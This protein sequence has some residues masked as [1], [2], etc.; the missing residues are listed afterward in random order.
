[1]DGE[2]ITNPSV[3]MA[4]LSNHLATAV[5]TSGNGKTQ[6]ATT[7]TKAIF[8]NVDDGKKAVFTPLAQIAED[9]AE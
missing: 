3:T 1:M 5:V 9:P 4:D 2:E 8:Q 6:S 7:L